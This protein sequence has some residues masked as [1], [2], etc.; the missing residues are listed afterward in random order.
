[1]N[2]L[3]IVNQC[4]LCKNIISDYQCLKIYTLEFTMSLYH[5][6]FEY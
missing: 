3:C 5:C 4:L 1:M 2:N 6:K